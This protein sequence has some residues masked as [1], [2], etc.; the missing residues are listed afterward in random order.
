MEKPMTG[1]EYTMRVAPAFTEE[2]C[3]M[4]VRFLTSRKKFIS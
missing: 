1:A 3:R 4:V 2:K